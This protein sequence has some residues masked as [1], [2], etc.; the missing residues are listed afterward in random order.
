VS[1]RVAK[2]ALYDAF[3]SV[4]AALGSVSSS[5]PGIGQQEIRWRHHIEQLTR[6]ECHDVFVMLRY[7]A[8]ARRGPMPPLP[9]SAGMYWLAMLE[10][11]L[12]PPPSSEGK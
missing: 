8:N 6:G 10:I 1:E 9:S 7:A 11:G 2:A 5:P 4:A 12:P 3:A